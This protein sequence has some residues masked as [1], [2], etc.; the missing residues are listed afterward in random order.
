LIKQKRKGK[1]IWWVWRN[2]NTEKKGREL[3]YYMAITKRRLVR[4]E[5]GHWIV[6]KDFQITF[7][8]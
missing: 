2:M 4:S 5:C 1:D 3:A 7:N 6:V 8:F